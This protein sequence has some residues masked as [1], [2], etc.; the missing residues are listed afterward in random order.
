MSKTISAISTPLA[1]GGLGVIRISGD[2]AFLIADKVFK[3]QNGKKIQDARG[4]TALFGKVYDGDTCLD[5]AVALI[6]RAPKSY[7]GENV[8]ELSVH[9][10]IY[11]QKTLLRTILSAGAFLAEPGEF[12]KR[13]FL[14]GKIDLAQ[15]ESVASIISAGGSQALKASLNAKDGAVSKKIAEIRDILLD[16]ASRVA[17]FSDFP[18]EEPSFSGIDLL[19][20]KIET[21][22]GELDLLIKNYDS[23]KV[24]REGV[25][26]AII[27]KPNVGKSTIMNLL[28]GADRS[29]VTA[30]AGT[31]RDIVEET[32]TVDGIKLNLS[33]TAGIRETDNEAEKIG[34]ERAKGK[35]NSSSLVLAVADGSSALDDEEKTIFENLDKNCSIAVINKN[36]L[37]QKTDVSFFEKLGLKTV[38]ISAKNGTGADELKKAITEMLVENRLSGNEVTL[39]SER[40][41]ECVMRAKTNLADAEFTLANGFTVDAVGICIDDAL[42]ALFELTGDRATVSVVDE[43]FK[44]FCVGK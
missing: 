44:K 2:D 4:Y 26:T 34:V 35:L 9:G 24:Y 1:E 25:T 6:F 16:C 21:A 40:Q 31:T 41:R 28:V 27:G 3:S 33:D 19:Q 32:V 10:G 12:T 38:F 23:G 42:N 7:T 20:G 43:V 14:N 37:A 15:A 29:I 5:E 8:V 30:A 13:A 22:S 39:V 17:A 11:I 18:D 36:D